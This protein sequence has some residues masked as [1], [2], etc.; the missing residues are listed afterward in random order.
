MYILDCVCWSNFQISRSSLHYCLCGLHSKVLEWFLGIWVLLPCMFSTIHF[1]MEFQT[2]RMWLELFHWLYT[3]LLLSRSSSMCSL[4]VGRM[5]VVKVNQTLYVDLLH[6]LSGVLWDD[7]RDK[8]HMFT[9]T[10]YHMQWWLFT[11]VY[12]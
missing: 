12:L 7:K 10:A 9:V 11:C 6:Q 5:T 4:F 2:R 1:L 3:L 8:V